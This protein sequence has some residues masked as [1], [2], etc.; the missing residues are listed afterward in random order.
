MLK[1]VVKRLLWFI[2]TLFIVTLLGFLLLVYSPGD[3]LD[4]LVSP[5]TSKN[6][7]SNDP[8]QQKTFWRQQLGLDLPLFYFS[9]CTAAEPDTLYKIYDKE[10]LKTYKALLHQS[11]NSETVNDYF[12]AIQECKQTYE[13]RLNIEKQK[14]PEAYNNHKIQLST[15]AMSFNALERTA[16]TT[17][18]KYHLHTLET[19]ASAFSMKPPDIY[20]PI[21]QSIK[22]LHTHSTKYKNYIPKIIWYGTNNRYHHWLFGNAQSKGVIRGDFGI[23]YTKKEPVTAIIKDKIIWSLFFSVLSIILA[24]I[25]SIPIGIRLAQ[26]PESTTSKITQIALFM[27]YSMPSF[28][29]G[30]LLLMLFSNPDILSVFP[31]SGIK[32]ISG[33]D[34]DANLFEKFY[35]SLPYMVLPLI[36]YTYSSLAYISRLTQ[37]SI[38]EQLPLDYIKTAK[39]KGLS[40][41]E[42]I[43]KHAL[44]NSLLPLIT[45]FSA[46]FPSIIGGS[47]IIESIFTIPGMG[48]ETV[49]AIIAKDFPI[50]IAV[51][52][53]SSILTMLSYLIAD[54]L[55]AWADPRIRYK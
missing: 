20:G 21:T 10:K 48:L 18:Q 4:M 9:V 8:E 15:I 6:S 2:P 39:A 3:P 5:L 49:K 24:Y 23:S 50:V 52:T 31:P 7:G 30:V 17:L 16:D 19:N 43:W 46:V 32:P 33:Y 11:G 29:I 34:E 44:K 12:K 28:F 41:K 40:E 37:T 13:I 47:V 51:I 54:V 25:I 26:K 1:Y 55:Y 53:L 42:V 14:F 45:V 27:L 36:C 38:M 22:K 35:E